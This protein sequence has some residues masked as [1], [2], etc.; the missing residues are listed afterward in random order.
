MVWSNWKG[1]LVVTLAWAG[2]APAQQ[3]PVASGERLMTVQEMGKP[4]LRWETDRFGNRLCHVLADRVEHAVDFEAS[5]RVERWAQVL[6]FPSTE[7]DPRDTV[8]YA[9]LVMAF[10]LARLGEQ[11]GVVMNA[12]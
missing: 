6:Q 2:L 11:S 9:Q 8:A 7:A 10:G 3:P 4:T 5:Y 12:F 1:A